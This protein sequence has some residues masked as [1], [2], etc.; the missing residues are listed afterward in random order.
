MGMDELLSSRSAEAP[1]GLRFDSLRL[2]FKNWRRAM[3]SCMPYVRR[4]EHHLVETKLDLALG[5]LAD[6]LPQME[7]C[8]FTLV[9]QRSA[10]SRD[11][12]LFVTHAPHPNLKAHVV[13]HIQRLQARGVDVVLIVNTD[14]PFESI[15]VPAEVQDCRAIY[16]R[17]NRGFDFGA[18][19]QVACHG[20]FHE[21]ASRLFLV[22]DSV[23]GPLDDARFRELVDNIRNCDADVIGLTEALFPRRHLQSYF[24]VFQRRALG[25]DVFVQWARSVRLLPTKDLV[26]DVYE[27]R[28]TA[29]FESHGLNCQAIFPTDRTLKWC[30]NDT[31]Y[32]WQQLLGEGFPYIKVSVLTRE[33]RLGVQPKVS[34]KLWRAWEREQS[35]K[36]AP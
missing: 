35:L 27:T 8:Q 34:Q 17:E 13:H 5:L 24:L 1:H 4:R 7:T 28:L 14:L 2:R 23:F 31:S 26:I 36:V 16:L 18:W 9:S 10:T 15:V 3:K 33:R 11:V 25:G 21:S 22:N 12:C 30:S 29:H 20:R 6:G 32:R 19:A